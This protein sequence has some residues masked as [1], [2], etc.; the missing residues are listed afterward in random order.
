M[1]ARQRRWKLGCLAGLAALLSA[2]TGCQTWVGGMTLPSGRYLEHP[3]QYFLQ[4]PPFPLQRELASMEEQAGL[5]DLS[6]SAPV[7]PPP[8]PVPGVPAPA[9]LQAP[10]PAGLPGR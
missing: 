5:I 2:L 1:S 7:A 10:A 6:D 3:P 9:P 8:A 4:D